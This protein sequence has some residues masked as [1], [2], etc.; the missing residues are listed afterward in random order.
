MVRQMATAYTARGPIVTLEGQGVKV[1]KIGIEAIEPETEMHGIGNCIVANLDSSRST[2]RIWSYHH[3]PGKI[4]CEAF[5]VRG[6]NLLD[7]KEFQV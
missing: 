5:G 1:L 6:L 4:Q 3:C 7:T 2:I